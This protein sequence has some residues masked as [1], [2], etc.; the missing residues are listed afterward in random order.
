[1]VQD[2]DREMQLHLQFCAEFGITQSE[3]EA[4]EENTGKLERPTRPPPPA[5]RWTADR[6]CYRKACTAYSRYV[7]D[8][9]QA[10]D[11]FALQVALTPCVIGYGAAARAIHQEHAPTRA[12]SHPYWKWVENYTNEDYMVVARRTMGE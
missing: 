11:W 5:T 4:T 12:D 7:L 3:V 10:E 9:G 2:L 8:I 6:S 1:M